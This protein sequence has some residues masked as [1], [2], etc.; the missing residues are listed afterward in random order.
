MPLLLK[1]LDCFFFK[2]SS[3]PLLLRVLNASSS[4]SVPSKWVNSMPFIGFGRLS[5][6]LFTSSS[7]PTYV[8]SRPVTSTPHPLTSGDVHLTSTHVQFT[9]TS[10]PTYVQLRPVTSIPRPLTSDLR[11]LTSGHVPLTSNSLPPHVRPTSSH[12]HPTSTHFHLTSDLRPVTSTPRPLTSGH[13]KGENGKD[14]LLFTDIHRLKT[15]YQKKEIS[16]LTAEETI[17]HIS[18][19]RKPS[20][21]WSRDRKNK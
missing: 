21:A 18:L 1:S 7:R 10:R 5:H 9:S 11:P 20:A 3:L 8:Q 14:K 13:G 6:V 15:T 4:K 19:N 17:A 2:E 12:V 16:L